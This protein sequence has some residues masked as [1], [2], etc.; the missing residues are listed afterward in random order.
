MLKYSA[1]ITYNHE[2][3]RVEL[4]LPELGIKTNSYAWTYTGIKQQDY[5]AV[6]LDMQT[7]ITKLMLSRKMI[8]LAEEAA[9]EFVLEADKLTEKRIRLSNWFVEQTTYRTFEEIDSAYEKLSG[10]VP[11]D[12]DCLKL[13]E[14]R[15]LFNLSELFDLPT[16]FELVR[17]FKIPADYLEPM[18]TWTKKIMTHPAEG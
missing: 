14:V 3:H 12:E 9:G 10:S 15:R 13:D 5:D 4:E 6:L 1:N 7:Q 17:V 8:P 16:Y 2:A 18:D 11:R